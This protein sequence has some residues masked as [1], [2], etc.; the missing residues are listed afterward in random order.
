MTPEDGRRHC[1][2]CQKSVHDVATLRTSEV[3]HLVRAT[4]DQEAPCIR[5]FVRRSDGA[6]L[7]RDGHIR[8]PSTSP[9]SA[10]RKPLPLAVALA[11]TPSSRVRPVPEFLRSTLPIQN[12]GTSRRRPRRLPPL[13]SPHRAER[14]TLGGRRGSA[15]CRP[16]TT[17]RAHGRFDRARPDS[18]RRK[19]ARPRRPTSAPHGSAEAEPRDRNQDRHGGHQTLKIQ[20]RTK[21]RRELAREDARS[22]KV[23]NAVGSD[24]GRGRAVIRRFP[25]GRGSPDFAKHERADRSVHML[26]FVRDVHPRMFA[27][28]VHGKGR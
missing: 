18:N 7:V 25:K 21:A 24:G 8:P 4:A 28:L 11:A 13:R 9:D 23:R 6:I 3:E 10:C 26:E 16:H 20:R 15:F 2:S 1:A 5:L 19:R 12:L 22:G 14:A 27:R 17:V